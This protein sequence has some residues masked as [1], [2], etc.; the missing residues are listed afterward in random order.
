MYGKILPLLTLAFIVYR[1]AQGTKKDEMDI[2]L[3]HNNRYKLYTEEE[4]LTSN[5]NLEEMIDDEL[6]DSASDVDLSC[7]DFVD[8]PK[9]SYG[10]CCF[11]I[12]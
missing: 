10:Q 9:V 1:I 4:E 8:E 5:D 3:I 6:T 2:Y 11:D 7:F 12:N